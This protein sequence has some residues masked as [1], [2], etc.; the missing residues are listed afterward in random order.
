[1]STNSSPICS[2]ELQRIL[3]SAQVK[4][5]HEDLK[6]SMGDPFSKKKKPRIAKNKAK[7]TITEVTTRV[8]RGSLNRNLPFASK[9]PTYFTV[10]LGNWLERKKV[11]AIIIKQQFGFNM[12]TT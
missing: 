9:L 1:M 5:N 10:S 11:T 3:D 12:S 2:Y 4:Q 8:T 6:K 7:K